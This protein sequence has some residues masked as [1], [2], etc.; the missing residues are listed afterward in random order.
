MTLVGAGPGAVDLITVRGQQAL[1]EADVIVYDDLANPELLDLSPAAAR[2]IYVG[3]RAG[4]HCMAQVA[5]GQIMVAEAAAGFHVVRLKGGDPLVFG[6]GGEELQVL[7]EAG[8]P[9]E[10]VPGVTAAS[11]AGASAGISL[12]QRGSASA[13]IFVTGHECGGKPAGEGVDWIAL[14]RTRATLCIY[15]GTRRIGVIAAEL[16]KGGLPGNTPVAVIANATMP[17]ET[18]DIGELASVEPLAAFAAGQPALI[19]V[20]EVVRLREIAAAAQANL[21]IV[22]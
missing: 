22:S 15:M 10:I 19:I 12:T 21:G 3:K 6:R 11:A 20:G 2:R 16:Q 18:I 17:E 9:C 5:I 13:V 1:R 7:A 4:R 14:A 8:I